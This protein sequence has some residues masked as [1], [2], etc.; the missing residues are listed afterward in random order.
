MSDVIKGGGIL[1]GPG[2]LPII[3]ADQSADSK[4]RSTEESD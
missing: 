4:T 1:I 3:L 2:I